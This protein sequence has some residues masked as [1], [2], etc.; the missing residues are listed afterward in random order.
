V[1]LLVVAAVAAERKAV[2]DKLDEAE[3]LGVDK[4]VTVVTG[5]VGIAAAAVATANALADSSYGAVLAIGIGGGFPGVAS[6]GEVVLADRIVAAD[7]GADSPVGFLSLEDLG[8]GTCSYQ[9]DRDLVRRAEKA[10]RRTR[11]PVVVGT[12]LTVS[13][14]TGTPDRAAELAGRVPGAAVEGME[15]FGAASAAAARGIPALEL[16]AISN[17]VGPR[18]RQSW[19]IPEALGELGVA[20]PAV[21]AELCR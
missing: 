6:M 12:A 17:P 3:G 8:F 19:R 10:L 20:V 18:N 15:G 4:D 5:G 14:V 11:L 16:R 13:T 7:L 21:A 9:P 2:L 1:R